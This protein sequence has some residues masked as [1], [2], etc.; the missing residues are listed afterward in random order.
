[1]N[2]W[3]EHR[4]LLLQKTASI[5]KVLKGP[6]CNLRLHLWQ[7]T[8]TEVLGLSYLIWSTVKDEKTQESIDKLFFLT[9]FTS[10]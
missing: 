1:M 4:T 8:W 10:L 3:H 5:Y 6:N 2:I 9:Y 7:H